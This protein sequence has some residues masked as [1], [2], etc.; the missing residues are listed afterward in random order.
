MEIWKIVMPMVN[1][2]V[3]CGV[4]PN[5]SIR[6]AFT[7]VKQRQVGVYPLIIAQFTLINEERN[8]GL[9]KCRSFRS[10]LFRWAILTI[11]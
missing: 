9:C 3:C 10:Q 7:F 5:L 11:H 6:S 4:L 1:T 2:C 8:T